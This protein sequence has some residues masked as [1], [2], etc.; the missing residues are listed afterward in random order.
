MTWKNPFVAQTPEQKKKRA[1]MGMG[2]A[3]HMLSNSPYNRPK[4]ARERNT[5]DAVSAGMK[6]GEAARKNKERRAKQ[7]T[8][9][10][11]L[12]KEVAGDSET[13]KTLRKNFKLAD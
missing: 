1:Q 5:M 4:G 2:M 10:T 7:K 12:A 9:K 3:Q 11:E 6:L 13:K 8:A